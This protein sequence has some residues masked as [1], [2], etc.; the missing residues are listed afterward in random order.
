[1]YLWATYDYYSKLRISRFNSPVFTIEE[2]GV[3][4]EVK[5]DL[6]YYPNEFHASGKQGLNLDLTF[7][8]VTYVPYDRAFPQAQHG[9]SNRIQSTASNNTLD[10]IGLTR[11][12]TLKW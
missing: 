6:K 11:R 7:L 3:Y 10:V 8:S 5:C 12:T 9:S 1:M 2:H 4:S